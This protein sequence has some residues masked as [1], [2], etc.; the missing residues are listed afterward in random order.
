MTFKVHVH[1]LAEARGMVQRVK[2]LPRKHRDLSLGLQHPRK[3]PGMTAH[4]Y[5]TSVGRQGEGSAARRLAISG[6]QV[7]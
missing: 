6:L 4:A 7:E 1:Y 5:N 3:K 2:C